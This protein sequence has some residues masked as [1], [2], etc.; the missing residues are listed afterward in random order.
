MLLLQN[1]RIEEVFIPN[2]KQFLFCD[3]NVIFGALCGEGFSNSQLSA[4]LQS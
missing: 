2:S 3:T 1:D 4:E